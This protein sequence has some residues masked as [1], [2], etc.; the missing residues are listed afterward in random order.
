[1][2]EALG[3]E[4]A[5]W[6]EKAICKRING[7]MREKVHGWKPHPNAGNKATCGDYGQQRCYIPDFT[8]V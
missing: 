7:I 1:M 2:I 8:A 5:R 3:F 4:Q 6:N